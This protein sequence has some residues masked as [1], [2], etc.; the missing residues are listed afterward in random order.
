MDF[1]RGQ[2]RYSEMIKQEA[3]NNGVKVYTEIIKYHDF[4]NGIHLPKEIETA[5]GSGSFEIGA[6]ITKRDAEGNILE[7]RSKDNVYTS[8]IYGFGNSVLLAKIENATIFESVT[9]K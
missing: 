3:F 1:L 5:K 7:Y 4:G 8:F 2:N 9:E 6:T